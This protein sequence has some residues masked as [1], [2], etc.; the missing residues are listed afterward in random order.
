MNTRYFAYGI[1]GTTY[2]YKWMATLATKVFH[3]KI[4]LKDMI[5]G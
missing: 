2:K 5:N 3:L 4:K 1:D